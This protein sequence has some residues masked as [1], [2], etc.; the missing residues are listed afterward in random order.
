MKI[1][2]KTHLNRPRSGAVAVE[3]AVVAPLLLLMLFG[4]FEYARFLFIYHVTNNACR[5]AARFAVCHTSGGTMPGE[6][7]VITTQNIRDIVT[8]GQFNGT[9]YGTG[10]GGANNSL[11]N[12]TVNVFGVTPAHLTANPPNLDPAGKPAW[13][14]T[15]FQ[16]KIAVQ[17]TGDYRPMF[18][19][20]L[21]LNT[22]VP[23]RV[24]ILMSSEA[25]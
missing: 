11:D 10:M 7:D 9:N 4:I 15:A 8:F 12:Y 3:F 19:Q 17:V 22:V 25:N 18:P 2:K 13:D 14:E 1:L 20:L 16:D 24:T 23:F 5:D 6:P 21:G